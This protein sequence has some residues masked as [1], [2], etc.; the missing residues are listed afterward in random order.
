M[1]IFNSYEIALYKYKTYLNIKTLLLSIIFGLLILLIFTFKVPNDLDRASNSNSYSLLSNLQERFYASTNTLLPDE[2][3]TNYKNLFGVNKTN[4]SGL[5]DSKLSPT[6]TPLEST[7]KI[8][9][10]PSISTTPKPK[11]SSKIASILIDEE[12]LSTVEGRNLER[13]E[14]MDLITDR[15]SEYYFVYGKL[16]NLYKNKS[17]IELGTEASNTIYFYNGDENR[18]G[19]LAFTLGTDEDSIL[20]S[21]VLDCKDMASVENKI[22]FTYLDFELKLCDEGG[23]TKSFFILRK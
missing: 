3:K 20:F 7:K 5:K 6:T 16:P 14:I 2:F 4:V 21:R 23:G 17:K 8:S 13:N 18:I 12:Y 10:K 19:A 9:L 11:S 15:I 1:N 22:S